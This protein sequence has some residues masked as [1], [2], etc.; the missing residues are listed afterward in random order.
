MV[1]N[2]RPTPLGFRGLDAL[3]TIEE[4]GAINQLDPV[5]E[6]AVFGWAK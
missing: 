4:A 1:E 6:K 5:V 2:G 3:R